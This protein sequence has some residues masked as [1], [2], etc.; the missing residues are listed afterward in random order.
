MKRFTL[1]ALAAIL[2]C[3]PTAH[4]GTIYVGIEDQRITGG[5]RDYQD[6]F[7]RVFGNLTLESCINGFGWQPMTAPNNNQVP[8]FDGISGDGTNMNFGNLALGTGGFTGNPASPNLTLASTQY[9][10]SSSGGYAP[11]TFFRWLGGSVTDTVLIEVSAWA[12]INN[13]SWFNLSSPGTLHSLSANA[14]GTNTFNPGGDFAFAF[15]S[16]GGTFRQDRDGGQFAFAQGTGVPEPG[17]L[18]LGSVG[19]VTIIFL[20]RRRRKQ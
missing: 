19:L 9:F 18:A 11:G 16:P 17:S 3:A 1:A 13:L 14:G 5:D 12:A 10:G 15:S 2:L 8:Y 6:Q 7:F 4:A 20:A